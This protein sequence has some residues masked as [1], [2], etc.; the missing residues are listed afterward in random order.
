MSPKIW[1]RVATLLNF[2]KCRNSLGRVVRVLPAA[3]SAGP[4]CQGVNLNFGSHRYH[5]IPKLNPNFQIWT[6][7]NKWTPAKVGRLTG[8]YTI[9]RTTYNFP[10][11]ETLKNQCKISYESILFQNC[12][13]NVKIIDFFSRKKVWI[14]CWVPFR[15]NFKNFWVYIIL[16]RL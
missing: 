2:K 7:K 9:K 5:K 12:F 15:H 14:F 16:Y 4:S 8:F 3:L 6:C 13:L 11:A 1:C 10:L